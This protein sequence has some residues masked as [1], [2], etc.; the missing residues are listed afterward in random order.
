MI[1]PWSETWNPPRNFGAECSVLRAK[2]CPQGRFFVNQH[3]EV[4]QQPDK[5]AVFK[6]HHVSKSQALAE[7]GAHHGYVHG[8]S[9]ITIQ[10]GNNQVACWEDR[11]RRAQALPCESGKRIQQANAPQPY[12]QASG[13]MEDRHPE[14]RSFQPPTGDPPRH[15]AGHEPGGYDQENRRAKNRRRLSSQLLM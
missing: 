15:Q 4:K 1:P 3:K 11:R 7:N 14:E 10:A 5:P 2:A 8:I 12:Q 13:K 9:N 6:Q